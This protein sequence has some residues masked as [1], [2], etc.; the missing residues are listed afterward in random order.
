M[1]KTLFLTAVATLL[2]V[3]GSF[4][5]QQSK[6]DIQA[7]ARTLGAQIPEIDGKPEYSKPI[8]SGD[9][10]LR[11]FTN[12]GAELQIYR[13]KRSAATDL[14]LI[15]YD[16]PDVPIAAWLKCFTCD[17]K[18]GALIAAELPFEI[19][20]ASHFDKEE[21]GEDHSYWRVS[22]RIFDNGNIL[23]LGSPGMAYLCVMFVRWDGKDGFTLYKRAGYDYMNFEIAADNAETE[24][25]VQKVVR[26]NFQRINAVAKWMWVEEEKILKGSLKGAIVTRYYS[27]NG[28]EKM[29]LEYSCDIFESV[30]EYYFLEQ[31]RLLSFVYNKTKRYTK[32]PKDV[33]FNPEKD[34]TLEER[35]WYLKDN[36]CFRGIG[37]DGKKLTPAQIQDEFLNNDKW[38]GYK[39]YQSIL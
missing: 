7:I 34:F 4:G 26:P 19:P 28:L 20:A 1:K 35:R 30:I 2:A 32:S 18:T 38:G 29:V 36:S 5:Q 11:C 6:N 8:E 9:N 23:I 17:R 24:K 14:V 31:R 39:T 12:K 3:A 16:A 15:S 10:Y 25:Y 27:G 21:F 37:N 13:Y 22:Y 33:N